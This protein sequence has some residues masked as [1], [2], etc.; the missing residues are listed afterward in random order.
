MA[1]TQVP[2]SMTDF[3]KPE[4]QRFTS[5]GTI[6]GYVFTVTAANA[7]IGAVYTNN[8]QSFTVLQTIVGATLLFCDRTGAP[9]TSGTLTRASGA[10]DATITFSNAQRLAIYTPNPLAKYLMVEM[11]GGGGGSGGGGGASAGTDGTPSY[12][13]TNLLICNGG[14]HGR[15]TPGSGASIGGSVVYNG[16]I[17]ERLLVGTTG[18]SGS[19]GSAGDTF[20]CGGGAGGASPFGGNGGGNQSSSG[21]SAATNS[22]SGGGGGGAGSGN[23]SC[24]GAAGGYIKAMLL[25]PESFYYYGVGAAGGAAGN[26]GNGGSGIIIVTEYFE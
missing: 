1:L 24:G 19:S 25:Q 6:A 18:S 21:S 13:G 14:Q 15:N 4:I 23:G 20:N 2:S 9:L 7:T 5:N 12:F 16:G 22:G 10:G 8:T 17:N 3:T 11:V 26:G